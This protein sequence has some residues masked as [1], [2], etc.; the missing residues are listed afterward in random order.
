LVAQRLFA[1]F[2]G[3]ARRAAQASKF[4]RDKENPAIDTGDDNKRIKNL[5]GVRKEIMFGKR[6]A[7]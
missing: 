5:A 1:L 7:L 6:A 4:R 2:C 3:A